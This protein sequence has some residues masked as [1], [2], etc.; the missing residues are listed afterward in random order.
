[1]AEHPVVAAL[2]DLLMI[3][4]DW[5]GLRRQRARLAEAATGRVLEIGV[6]TGLNLAHFTNATA[7][8][9]IDPDPHMLKRAKRRAGEAP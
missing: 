7:V 9:A 3:P 8:V 2:Y 4:N 1:M 6:G 5:L